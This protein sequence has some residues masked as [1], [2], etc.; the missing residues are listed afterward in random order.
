M[1]EGRNEMKGTEI[2]EEIPSAYVSI[3]NPSGNIIN[4]SESFAN[5][6]GITEKDILSMSLNDIARFDDPHGLLESAY[7]LDQLATERLPMLTWQAKLGK[8]SRKLVGEYIIVTKYV[9]KVID[10]HHVLEASI[11]NEKAVRNKRRSFI[12]NII[13]VDDKDVTDDYTNSSNCNGNHEDDIPM[14]SR[15]TRAESKFQEDEEELRQSMKVIEHQLTDRCST[16]SSGTSA[17][18]NVLIVDDSPMC[19]KV[20]GR[21]IT[22]MGHKVSTAEDGLAAL[23]QLRNNYFDI[24]LMDINMPTMNGLE[25]AHEFRKIEKRNRKTGDTSQK[26]IAMSGDISNT[27]FHEVTNAGF[28]TFIPKPLTSDKFIEALERPANIFE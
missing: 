16:K 7:L 6:C 21:M 8:R 25:A 13:S 20:A 28:D 11:L 24:V 26:I 2:S 19:L 10:G 14:T 12:A 18:K 15:S 23:N 3:S 22:S 9:E 27:L 17:V 4:C 5:A 1:R